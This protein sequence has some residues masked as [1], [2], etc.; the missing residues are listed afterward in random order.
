MYTTRTTLTE[1]E[2]LLVSKNNL[3]RTQDHEAILFAN[4]TQRLTTLP[5]HDISQQADVTNPKITSSTILRSPV[6]N[7]QEVQITWDENSYATNA[8]GSGLQLSIS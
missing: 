3:D 5:V 6:M 7:A 8:V 1:L 2:E 4:G